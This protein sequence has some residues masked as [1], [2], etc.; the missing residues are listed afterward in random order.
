MAPCK[1]VPYSTSVCEA[2]SSGELIG[3]TILSTVRNAAKLAVYEDIMIKVK[4]HQTHPTILPE[5]DLQTSPNKH[6][7][8]TQ[9]AA[10]TS[11]K[12]RNPAA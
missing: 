12:Y 11:E 10:V 3:A 4:N 7:E 9:A 2:R 8:Q 6:V 1:S 5:T